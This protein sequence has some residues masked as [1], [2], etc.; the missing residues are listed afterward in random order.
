MFELIHVDATYD[1]SREYG[2][3]MRPNNQRTISTR[4]Y[5]LFIRN[6]LADIEPA[7][8]PP[9][10]SKLEPFFSHTHW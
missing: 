8:N 2:K 10:P 6:K 9:L 7:E 3:N 4:L 5:T 1:V